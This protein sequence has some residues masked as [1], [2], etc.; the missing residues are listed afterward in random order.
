MLKSTVDGRDKCNSE[1]VAKWFIFNDNHDE[2]SMQ[3]AE[4]ICASN[5]NLSEMLLANVDTEYLL[6]QVKC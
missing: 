3:L 5:I 2:Q 1:S 4:I 6:M